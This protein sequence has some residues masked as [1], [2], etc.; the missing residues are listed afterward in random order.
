MRRILFIFG[1][2]L[3]MSPVSAEK[4]MLRS[5]LEVDG[6]ILQKTDTFVKIDF[7]GTPLIYYFTEVDSIDGEKVGK[8]V[9]PREERS[10]AQLLAGS[11]TGEAQKTPL[12]SSLKEPLPV[13]ALEDREHSTQTLPQDLPVNQ[14]V[15][16]P[17][18]SVVT[19]LAA[20]VQDAAKEKQVIPE[21]A[22]VASAK[23]AVS[24][25]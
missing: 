12:G 15:V 23:S 8:S 9:A 13:A 10:V 24:V 18:K 25:P 11:L 4:V 14:S 21:A 19:Q 6:R 20:P 2:L 1:F 7:L 17:T 22:G 16:E 5:G 3:L